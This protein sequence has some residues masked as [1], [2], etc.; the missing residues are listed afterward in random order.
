MDPLAKL[1]LDSLKCPLCQGRIDMLGGGTPLKGT[2]N[3]CCVNNWEHYHLWF[4]H[5]IPA[6]TI[7]YEETIIYDKTHKY[8]VNQQNDVD[9]T[10]LIVY[11]VDA[12]GNIIG[13]SYPKD[14]LPYS[15]KLFDFSKT[16]REK[17][18]N[19]VKTILV[20]Q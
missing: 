18:L 14:V 2:F 5:W 12:E 19:R 17:M 13:D 16:T 9:T 4:P 10:T 20:F 3:Y 6:S 11:E 15:K 8:V 1:M 7:E